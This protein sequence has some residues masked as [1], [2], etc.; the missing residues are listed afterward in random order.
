MTLE[1]SKMSEIMNNLL[2]VINNIGRS[3]C[4]N[5]TDMFI[6]SGILIVFLLM[7]DML[8]RRRVRA[9]FR[10]CIWMLVLIKLVLPPSLSLPTGIG[11]WSGDFLP[12]DSSVSKQISMPNESDILQVE[13]DSSTQTE[14]V[15]SP[16][17][18]DQ[19]KSYDI[20][21]ER[22]STIG[23]T[24][25][26]QV[27]GIDPVT[28]TWQGIIFVLW[29]IG[30]VIL[31]VLL[32]Q[33]ILF[34]RGLISQSGPVSKELN[35]LL[36]QCRQK[37]GISRK[38]ELRLITNI[39]SPAVCGLYKPIIL[40]P[41]TL[42]K[43]LPRE[44]LRT[45]IIHELAH[46][47]R[48]D[49][50]INCVQT[51]LQIFYFYNPLVWFANLKI[52]R[53]R[54]QAVDEM[55]LVVLGAEAKSY[56]NTLI[57]IAEM[58]FFKTSLSLRLIGVVESKKALQGRIKHMLARPI[59]KN[60]K[61]GLFG[62]LII[63]IAAAVLL[64]MAKG[65]F[66]EEDVFDKNTLIKIDSE[67][68]YIGI[69]KEIGNTKSFSKTYD[70]VFRKGEKLLVV[71]ELYKAGEPMQVLGAKIFDSPVGAEKLSSSFSFSK[72]NKSKTAT[73]H[74]GNVKLGEQ[75][76]DIPE[77]KVDKFPSSTWWG[78]FNGDA[79][80]K[81]T[82]RLGRDSEAMKVLF[83]YAG[84]FP[85]TNNKA[86]FWIPAS[87]TTPVEASYAF[88]LKAI[89]LSRLE[90]L[91]V[92]PIGSYQGLGG[93]LIEP[94]GF[95]LG[96]ADAIADE[97]KYELLRIVNDA[98]VNT[99]IA[100]LPNGVTVELLGI[101]EYPT[102]GKRWWRPDGSLVTS[103]GFGDFNFNDPYYIPENN[104]Y[105]RVFAVKLGG[106]DFDE[107]KLS[108]NINS[109]RSSFYPDYEDENTKKLKP[110]QIIIAKFSKDVQFEDLTIR[111]AVGSW[112]P[113][114][115]GGDGRTT[116]ST[117]D[118]ITDRSV[119]FHEAVNK[120]G[121]LKLSATHL[122]G[123]DYDCR[124][125]VYDNQGKLHEPLKR[126]NSGSEM[127]LCEGYFD[128]ISPDQIKYI[129]LQARPYEWTTFK[130]VSL[131]PGVKTDV[132][133]VADLVQ[134]EHDQDSVIS[135][136]SRQRRFVMLVVGLEHMTFEGQLVTWGQLPEM[137]EKIPSRSNTVLCMGIESDEMTMGQ[138]NQ[139]NSKTESLSRQF[140]FEYFSYVGVH[141]LG[142]RGEPVHSIIK[143]PLKFNEEIR[144][145]LTADND[146]N[147]GMLICSYIKFNKSD[148]QID[149]LLDLL[150]SSSP[151]SK[152]EVR[153]ML[154]D[155]KDRELCSDTKIVEN[156]GRALQVGKE[157]TV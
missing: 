135:S 10:Y 129:G 21:P 51:L 40:I 113:V 133:I 52:R 131:R 79:L 147:L 137:L 100:T 68:D 84:N 31:F 28:F 54:E 67:S 95:T 43:Q 122:L 12:S 143:G 30:V 132:Q 42:L 126:S 109:L 29:L 101:C 102:T 120:D 118:S 36:N 155:T 1:V 92:Q 25:P 104:E 18:T 94:D 44:K 121:N 63:I 148:N 116:S 108:W 80:R 107:V 11:Y 111:L 32:I 134:T 145:P 49:L 3:F 157:N 73:K 39:Q 33:R 139:A 2:T 9:T 77:F 106:K 81:S 26:V 6:Q 56:S 119:I 114:A 112:K 27:Q 37:I 66:N 117:N 61:L 138:I 136:V 59:P 146:K 156:S 53:I 110:V 125:V 82:D 97:Y 71:A 75:V 154:F 76:F 83:Y 105:T 46:L 87:N 50:W 23:T 57:D 47:K 142:L 89:P 14:T 22:I 60:A 130:E 35:E 41:T 13:S 17:Q 5:A 58:A 96:M 15:V 78:W 72:T 7:V 88:V 64:P 4:N 24:V 149:A 48:E 151:K 45:V 115:S 19:I 74:H 124:I 150:I 20:N 38:T 140:G 16:V 152:W 65:Q 69:V 90:K 62:L 93:K 128:N 70:V 99:C 103:D 141:D 153:V 144:L 98:L 127:R 123:S 55:V 8:I 86:R 91:Y 34:V 85:D